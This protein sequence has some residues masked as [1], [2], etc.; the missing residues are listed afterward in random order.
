MITLT[1]GVGVP[2]S[3][4]Q[5]WVPVAGGSWTLDAQVLVHVKE[6]L[7]STIA[8]AAETQGKRLPPWTAY[9]LQYQPQLVDGHRTILIRGACHVSPTFDPRKGFEEVS[10]GG[11]CYFTVAY[12]V[13]SRHFSNVLFNGDA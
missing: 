13:E 2:P 3:W 12:S 8:A 9:T 10:D 1:F 7:E 5:T 6:T 11:E 4:A